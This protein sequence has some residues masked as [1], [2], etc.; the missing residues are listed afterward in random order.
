VP[1]P[2]GLG[3]AVFGK[4]VEGMDV[5]DRI[6]GVRTAQGRISEA[7]PTEPVVIEKAAAQETA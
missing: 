4:V 1:S 5:L 6:A 3:Y 7:V 2:A